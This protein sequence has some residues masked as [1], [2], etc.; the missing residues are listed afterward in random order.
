MNQSPKS[1]KR[2]TRFLPIADMHVSKLNMRH[3]KTP[4]AIDDIYPSILKSGIHQSLLVRKEGKGWGV[5]AGRRRL[6]ALK[7][8]AKETGKPVKAPCLIMQ[9]GNVKAAREAS[10]LEN[11]ARLPASSVERFTAFKGLADAGQTPTDI[12]ETFGVTEISVRQTL[13]LAALKPEILNLYESDKIHSETLRALT[14]ATIEQQ[15]EWLEL[16]HG[17]DY[18]P[19]GEQLKAWLTGSARIKTDVALFDL[20][21]YSGTTITD[22][23][24]ETGYFSDPD[25]FWEHQ[26]AAIAETLAE[27]KDAGWSDVVLLERGEH[28][29]RWEHG[30]RSMEQ[31]GKVFVAIGHDGSV[32]LHRGYLSNSDIK[33]IDAILGNGGDEDAQKPA[34]K[35]ELSGPLTEYI[36]L[37]RHAAIRSCLIDH[38]AIALRL[39][40]AH[41]LTSAG[42]WS[43]DAQKTKA[44]KDTTSDSVSGGEGAKRFE[45]ERQ[46]VYQLLDLTLPE[47][48]Y[49]PARTLT[50]NDE[51]SLFAALLKAD[52]ATVMRALTVAMCMSLEA[53]S[54]AVE[55][56]TYVMPVD[57]TALWRPDDAFFDLL[58][59]KRVVNAL[60]ADIA[61]QSCAD[62]ALTDTGK[63]QKEIIRNRIAGH[64]VKKAAT[65]W[66]PRWMQIPARNYFE[67]D[68]CLPAQLDAA[69]SK[70]MMSDEKANAA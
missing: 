64:G 57:M 61:G 45:T 39:A 20:D 28:F 1:T 68:G 69:V 37:H 62:A 17:E 60:V 11:V 70:E 40:V 5:I 12:A 36:C 43:V 59:D 66:R 50:N 54:R 58:R 55:A 67:T 34:A 14:L 27:L 15:D 32:T 9:N 52:D 48:T 19:Q 21:S 44:R 24:G 41:M 22:L 26:N 38:P 13:A 33:K 51:I 63:K 4:P 16:Y 3:G 7:K 31:G 53:G 2:D 6:F 23:F 65:D 10:L 25:L 49:G 42:N 30:E 18:A 8:K 56:L 47:L 35:P 46:E 29:I